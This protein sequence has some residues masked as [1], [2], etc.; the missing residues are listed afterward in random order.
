MLGVPQRGYEY[1]RE[2]I[3]GIRAVKEV[4]EGMVICIIQGAAIL[5]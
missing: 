3:F 1:L 5:S 4:P 2:E